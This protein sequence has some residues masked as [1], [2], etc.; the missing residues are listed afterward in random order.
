M[1]RLNV[2]VAVI[3]LF[4]I[5]MASVYAQT[6]EIKP[7]TIGDKVPDVEFEN[8]INYSDKKVRLSDFK[9]KLMILDFWAT[10]CTSCIAGIS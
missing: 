2:A 10:W 1:K 6:N 7:L 3:A 4:C 8:V 5:S 9:G